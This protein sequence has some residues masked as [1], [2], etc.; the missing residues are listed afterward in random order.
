MLTLV[1]LNDETFCATVSFQKQDLFRLDTGRS[2]PC[3]F[4]LRIMVG[5]AGPFSLWVEGPSFQN[6]CSLY[7]HRCCAEFGALLLLHYGTN[8]QKWKNILLLKGHAIFNLAN[9]SNF[10]RYDVSVL[11]IFRL[12]HAHRHTSWSTRHDDGAFLERCALWSKR[13]NFRDVE[14]QI[15]SVGSLTGLAVDSSYEIERGS[16]A[17]N[18]GWY[19]SRSDRRILVEAL[20]ETPLWNATCKF[21]IALP[22]AAG[23]VVGNGVPGNVFTDL[24]NRDVLACLANDNGLSTQMMN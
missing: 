10:Y 16:F 15:G 8:L 22:V 18:L 2:G 1:S 4:G 13:Y 3:I 19:N 5:R 12:L 14:Q 6:A 17:Q 9:A 11:Q 20:A 7:K 23:D 24:F 21:G